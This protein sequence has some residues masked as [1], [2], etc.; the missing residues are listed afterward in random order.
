MHLSGNGNP[1]S[2]AN[3]IRRLVRTDERTYLDFLHAYLY[4]RSALSESTNMH[5]EIAHL[6]VKRGLP[7]GPRWPGARWR[8]ARGS[9]ANRFRCRSSLGF[10]LRHHFHGVAK[11]FSLLVFFSLFAISQ[12]QAKPQR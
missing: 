1:L 10:N 6:S 8:G 2:A 4:L 11:Q 5:P 7:K 12:K 9:V 3:V